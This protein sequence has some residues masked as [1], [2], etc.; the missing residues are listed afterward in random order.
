[1]VDSGHDVIRRWRLF[2]VYVT[3]TVTDKNAQAR[4]KKGILNCFCGDCY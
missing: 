1:M 3:V 2:H 4:K